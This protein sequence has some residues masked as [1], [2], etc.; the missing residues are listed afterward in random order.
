[1]PT[2]QKA[3]ESTFL[4]DKELFGSPLDCS[5]SGGISYCPAFPKDKVF[6]ATTN[7]FR[8]RWTGSCI[9]NP[10]YELEDI[11]K[12]ALH[13]LSSSEVQDIPFLVV[14]ILPVWEDAP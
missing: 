9:A 14:L 4:S 6:G 1:M 12:A 2:L 7:S 10:K 11:L 13:A 8:Y 3:L 5:M